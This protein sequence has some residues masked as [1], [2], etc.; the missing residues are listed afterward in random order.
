MLRRCLFR[1]VVPRVQAEERPVLLNKRAG[2]GRGTMGWARE[3]LNMGFQAQCNS[4]L[5]PNKFLG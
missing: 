1:A 3:L 2:A 4:F 5:W